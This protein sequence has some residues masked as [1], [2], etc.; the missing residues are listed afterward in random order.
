MVGVLVL[1][2]GCLARELLAAARRIAGD[3]ERFDALCLEWDAS[4]D[5]ARARI[6]ES[7]A[8]LDDGEGVL[9]LTDVFGGTPHKLA[10]SAGIEGRYALVS[11][12][13]LPMVLRLACSKCTEDELERLVAS[14][15]ERG[16]ESIRSCV[17]EPVVTED[18]VTEDRVTADR[19][20]EDRV[21]EHAAV[22]ARVRSTGS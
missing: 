21:T 18:M 13:N 16:R 20:T 9:I 14:V 10:T 2:H 22:P 4:Q 8:R 12:V 5:Q 17:P 19:V 3:L 7:A 1:S 6:A 11:G 15:E